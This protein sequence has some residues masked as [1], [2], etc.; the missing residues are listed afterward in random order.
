[1]LRLDAPAGRQRGD[2]GET[3]S[4]HGL[5]GVLAG[6]RQVAAGVLDFDPDPGVDVA[7]PQ[8]HRRLAVQDG[9]GQQFGDDQG[10]VV[11][12]RFGLILEGG[13]GEPAG[14]GDRIGL[15]TEPE[16]GQRLHHDPPEASVTAMPRIMRAVRG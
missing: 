2:E 5:G 1:M 6:H 14:A 12:E 9:V 16:L 8:R 7:D 3:A 11:D 10:G 15:R 13:D 4:G